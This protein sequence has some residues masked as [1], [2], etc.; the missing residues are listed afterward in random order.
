MKVAVGVVKTSMFCVVTT[1]EQ[2]SAITRS[3]TLAFPGAEKLTCVLAADGELNVLPAKPVQVKAGLVPLTPV[4]MS[5]EL[6]PT[7]TEGNEILNCDEGI[8]FT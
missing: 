3:D 7:Q 6:T 5:V 8:G 4:W 1:D 2:P